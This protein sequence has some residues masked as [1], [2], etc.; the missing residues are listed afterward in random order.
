MAALAQRWRSLF[1][2]NA[3][4]AFAD[5]VRRYAEPGRSYHTLDHIAAVLDTIEWLT[6][7]PAPALLLAGWFHDVVYDSRASDNEERS[8]DHA[9]RTLA[10]LGVNAAVQDE[11]ARLILLTKS[12]TAAAAADDESGQILLDAD[13][14]ILGA[15]PAVY[16][17]YAAAIRREYAWVSEADYRAGR[18]PILEKFLSRPRIYFTP[19]MVARA[20]TSARANLAREIAALREGKR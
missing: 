3:D 18:R 17:A 20:E 12:H 1:T 10:S 7:K 4:E 9:R 14:A 8:A 6:G 19:L 15:E 2:T 11:A 16:D 13:L 5:L